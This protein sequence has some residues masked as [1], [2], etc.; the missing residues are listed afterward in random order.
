M[1]ARSPSDVVRALYAAFTA[2]DQQAVERLLTA[3]FRFTSPLDNALDRRTWFEVCWPN[4]AAIDTIDLQH[5]LVNGD[6]VA[7]IYVAQTRDGRRF[8]NSELLTCR[9]ARIC[10]V[11]VYFGWSLPHEVRRGAHMTPN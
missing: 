9:G 2:Q 10:D 8:R 5:V 3:D 11:E 1:S 7:V 4:S 6:T